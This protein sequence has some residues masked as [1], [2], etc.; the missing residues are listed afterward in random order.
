MVKRCSVKG[1]APFSGAARTGLLA[2]GIT[3]VVTRTPKAPWKLLVTVA[4]VASLPAGPALAQGEDPRP[5][6]FQR[7]YLEVETYRSGVS[8]LRGWPSLGGLVR[9]SRELERAV[10]EDDQTLSGELLQ[11]F[12]SKA[13][14]LADEPLPAFLEPSADSVA[15]AFD[16]LKAHLDRADA[17][18]EA[19]PPA[20]EV[21][22]GEA[23]NEA[24]RQRTLVT[25][26]TAVTVPAGV[27]VGTL[28]SLPTAELPGE[29][30]NFVDLV[31]LALADLD[32]L[33]H[34]VRTTGS[35]PGAEPSEAR[36]TPG[37]TPSG[38]TGRPPRGP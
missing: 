29:E 18:L 33:V 36:A 8:T 17:W 22:E 13:D 10:A 2:T 21:T 20:P 35:P 24:G 11:V 37:A 38:D 28:D 9:W 34:L 6:G 25:G 14:S 19:L 27:Q 3:T 4:M 26:N 12:R 15:A 30:E 31:N 7:Q 16:S 5:G 32:R 23:A 1:L